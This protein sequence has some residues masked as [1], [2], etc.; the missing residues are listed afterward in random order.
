MDLAKPSSAGSSPHLLSMLVCF[1]AMAVHQRLG[2]PGGAPALA[3]LLAAV[4]L[5]CAVVLWIL[6]DARRHGYRWPY[7]SDHWLYLTWPLSGP[8]YLFISRGWRGFLPL[9][10]FFLLHIAGTVL[11]N[12]VA[13]LLRHHH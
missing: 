1:T 11:G 4:L 10:S 3:Y 8:A 5:S 2:S 7:D 9:G 12:A 6:K 13:L